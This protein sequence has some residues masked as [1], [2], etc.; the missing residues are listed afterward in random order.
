MTGY[1]KVGATI[2]L[3]GDTYCL[4]RQIVSLQ[5]ADIPYDEVA[6]AV[7]TEL[8]IMLDAPGKKNAVIMVFEE[9]WPWRRREALQPSAATQ[10][11]PPRPKIDLS[12]GLRLGCGALAR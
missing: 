12:S 6:L 4:E 9:F 2:Y 7:T 10:R 3:C 1:F 5:L 8:G 11:K